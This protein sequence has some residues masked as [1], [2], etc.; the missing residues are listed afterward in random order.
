MDLLNVQDLIS[1]PHGVP[2]D[3]WSCFIALSRLFPENCLHLDKAL[4]HQMVVCLCVYDRHVHPNVC[5][6][7]VTLKN[8]DE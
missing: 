1:H 6:P 3:R 8:K 4:E 2:I 5:N 7:S